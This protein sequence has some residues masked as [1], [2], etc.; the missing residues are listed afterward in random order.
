MS[1]SWFEPLWSWPPTT[2]SFLFFLNPLVCYVYK[3]AWTRLQVHVLG[4]VPPSVYNIGNTVVW[5]GWPTGSR[6]ETEIN[7]GGIIQKQEQDQSQIVMVLRSSLAGSIAGAFIIPWISNRMGVLLLAVSKRSAILRKILAAKLQARGV[8]GQL[9]TT[10]MKG[11]M[12]TKTDPVW[13]RNT[14]GFGLFVVVKDAIELLRLWLAMRKLKSGHMKTQVGTDSH[15]H[16]LDP[17]FIGLA[18]TPTEPQRARL[19]W[20]ARISRVEQERP[21]EAIDRDTHHF[22]HIS[23]LTSS[24]PHQAHMDLT[25]VPSQTS[26]FSRDLQTTDHSD[27]QQD[28][29]QSDPYQVV[30]AQTMPVMTN[31]QSNP[32]RQDLP[33]PH[34]RQWTLGPQYHQQAL[35]LSPLPIRTHLMTDQP[36][37]NTELITL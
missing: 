14:L 2:T 20:P 36:R 25:P 8:L 33:R 21:M 9:Q 23:T 4:C 1:R 31:N 32:T 19:L 27:L 6:I 7:D 26:P 24:C 17:G 11:S 18:S 10:S 22:S 30:C 37:T 34:H 16:S 12:W 28:P 5:D 15:D 13:W 29:T 35:A 3:K